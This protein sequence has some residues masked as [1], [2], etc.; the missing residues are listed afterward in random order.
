[1]S[2]RAPGNGLSGSDGGSGGLSFARFAFKGVEPARVGV[3]VDL[4]PENPREAQPP[5][6]W[7]GR[8]F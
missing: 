7:Q 3:I 1:M 2:H 4:A 6:H 5:G 8:A